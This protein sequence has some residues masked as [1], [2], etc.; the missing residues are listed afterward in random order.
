M[1]CITE[2]T[3]KFINIMDC[4]GDLFDFAELCFSEKGLIITCTDIN[5]TIFMDLELNLSFFT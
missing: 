2:N 5:K 4:I 1:K 3:Q